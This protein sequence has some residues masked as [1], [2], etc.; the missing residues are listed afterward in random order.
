[1]IDRSISATPLVNAEIVI[2][3]EG[4]APAKLSGATLRCGEF[5][6]AYTETTK[7]GLSDY[8]SGYTVTDNNYTEQTV[9]GTPIKIDEK[10]YIPIVIG[11]NEGLA[12]LVDKVIKGGDEEM[13]M[14]L[15][16]GED[17]YVYMSNPY[18]FKD[19]VNK[20]GVL[21]G[22]TTPNTAFALG[23][24]TQAVNQQGT[25]IIKPV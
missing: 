24:N 19:N 21:M 7:I 3:G 1:M 11:L 10:Y 25:F 22:T 15:T 4:T 23:I 8:I 5:A 13:Y 17:V 20:N 12:D 14:C 6:E 18:V 2:G 16:D 9:V